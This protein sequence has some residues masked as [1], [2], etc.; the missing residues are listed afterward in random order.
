MRAPQS[1]TPLPRY[2]W[3]IRVG[4][5]FRDGKLRLREKRACTGTQGRE[6][7]DP[8]QRVGI[9]GPRPRT[10]RRGTDHTAGE[11]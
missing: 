11:P 5:H 2:G 1:R 7:Y 8:G 3:I 4:D 10:G 6:L 9:I